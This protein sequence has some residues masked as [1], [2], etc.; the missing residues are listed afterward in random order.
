MSTVNYKMPKE[1]SQEMYKEF[2]NTMKN[3]KSTPTKDCPNLVAELEK[4]KKLKRKTISAVVAGDDSG[5][6]N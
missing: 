2:L 6:N 4:N 1:M 3:G 5:S